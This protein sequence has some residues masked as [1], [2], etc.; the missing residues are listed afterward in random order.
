[1]SAAN[2]KLHTFHP[3]TIAALG[4]GHGWAAAQGAGYKGALAH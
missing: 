2:L 3:D 4:V 1:M